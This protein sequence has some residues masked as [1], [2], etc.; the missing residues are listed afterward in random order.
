MKEFPKVFGMATVGEKGQI[1]VP[2]EARKLL[3]IK[4]GDKLIVMSGP[5]HSKMI[6]L[7]RADEVAKFLKH[8]EAHISEVK[9]QLHKRE[10]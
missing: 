2:C 10:K 5:P 8:F 9:D 1:V 4:S 7:A 6:N 3:D